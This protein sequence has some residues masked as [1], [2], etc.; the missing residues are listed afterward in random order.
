M[1]TF[2]TDVAGNGP[3]ILLPKVMLIYIL[4]TVHDTTFLS[5][6]GYLYDYWKYVPIY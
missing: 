5:I 4:F 3:L 2:R 1:L 6:K